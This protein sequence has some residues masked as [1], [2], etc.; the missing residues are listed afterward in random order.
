MI[1]SKTTCS[2]CAMAKKV[3]D[4]VGVEYVVVEINQRDDCDKLQDMLEK[5]T[6]QRSVSDWLCK[7]EGKC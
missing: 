4:E 6:G 3:L 5:I 2:Y 1:F 7:L